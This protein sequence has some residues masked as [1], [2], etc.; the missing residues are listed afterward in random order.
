MRT[1]NFDPYQKKERRGSQL[2]WFRRGGGVKI[3][4]LLGDHLGKFE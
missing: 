2:K 1:E 4:T 3:K